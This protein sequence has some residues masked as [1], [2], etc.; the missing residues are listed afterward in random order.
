MFKDI[1]QKEI[2]FPESGK[3]LFDRFLKIL[4]ILENFALDPA[5]KNVVLIMVGHGFFV[6]YLYAHMKNEIMLDYPYLST[7]KLY[8]D[9]DTK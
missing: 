4:T 7:S 3:Q 2:G 9:S 5:N 6:S 8:F 1:R